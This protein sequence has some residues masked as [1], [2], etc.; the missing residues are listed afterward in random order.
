MNLPRRFKVRIMSTDWTVRVV[1]NQ[2]THVG[3]LGVDD[4]GSA[5]FEKMEILIS[6]HGGQLA[7]LLHEIKEVIRKYLQ[8][9]AKDE[10]ECSHHKNLERESQAEAGVIVNNLDLIRSFLA[11]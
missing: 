8:I 6:K 3:H 10:A 5:D 2:K 11:E 9:P 7:S 4:W 1:D